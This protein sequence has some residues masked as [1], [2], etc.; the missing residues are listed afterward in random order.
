MKKDKNGMFIK[1]GKKAKRAYTLNNIKDKKF[2]TVKLDEPWASAIGTPELSGSWF[3]YGLP[4][5]G[6]TTM[7]LQL[8]KMLSRYE[9]IVYN[10]I[11]EGLS[12]SLRKCIERVGVYACGRRF[13]LVKKEFEELKNWLY[14]KTQRIIV[15]DSVQFMEITFEQYKQLKNE[16]PD[17]LF[18]YISHVENSLPEGAVARKI[19]RDSNVI[20]KVEMLKSTPISRYG[21]NGTIDLN[22]LTINN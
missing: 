2:K 10:S 7:A 16:F 13:I 1:E 3:I 14:F 4:K 8:C 5:N 19:M 12:L 21:G 22:Q 20:M 15:I 6:K 9:R 18:I 11:E 17:K